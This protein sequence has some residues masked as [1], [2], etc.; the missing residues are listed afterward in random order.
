[1]ICQTARLKST[2]PCLYAEDTQIF[3]SSHDP[4]KIV[5]GV[6]LDLENITNWLTVNK[7]QSHPSKT[8]I[9]V[10]GSRYSV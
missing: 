9:M 7:L 10:I 5:G 8:K 3:G 6:N 4:A 1:M 2:F